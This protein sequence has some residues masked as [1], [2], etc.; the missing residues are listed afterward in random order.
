MDGPEGR[1]HPELGGQFVEKWLGGHYAALTF[2]HS[3]EY[4]KMS[5]EKPSKLCWADK[6]SVWCEPRWFYLLRARLSGEAE[7]F[8]AN[9]PEHVQRESD[10]FWL[11]WY[12]TKVLNL[13]EI[14]EILETL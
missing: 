14:R 7:E 13:K 9:A 1:T 8:K 4:A 5:G 11:N 10:R 6:Y 3:R 12:R 2:F